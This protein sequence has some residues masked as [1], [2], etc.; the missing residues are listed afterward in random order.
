MGG[1]KQDNFRAGGGL[2]PEIFF[3]GVRVRLVSYQK[4]TA[5]LLS[6]PVFQNKHNC[7]L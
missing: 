4:I 1:P 7:L 3:Q 5:S 6:K 2:V